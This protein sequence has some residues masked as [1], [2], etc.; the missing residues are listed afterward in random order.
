MLQLS[1]R[2]GYSA[3]NAQG[4][5]L[6]LVVV[7]FRSS[8]NICSSS[9]GAQQKG[10]TGW[11]SVYHQNWWFFEFHPPLNAHVLFCKF[12]F[13][14]SP[15]AIGIKTLGE[16]NS[17]FL[18]LCFSYFTDNSIDGSFTPKMIRI[19]IQI[20][21]IQQQ[22]LAWKKKNLQVYTQPP[23]IHLSYEH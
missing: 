22:R 18:V 11:N 21:K 15:C 14:I 19:Q 4:L 17:G 9:G 5:R 7:Q 12:F 8:E 2:C 1:M 23:P 6:I 13:L 16:P 3:F 10:K 20:T